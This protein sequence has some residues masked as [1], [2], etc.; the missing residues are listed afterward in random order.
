MNM[1]RIRRHWIWR[2]AISSAVLC[3]QS[4][5]PT[6]SI[7]QTVPP[8]DPAPNIATPADARQFGLESLRTAIANDGGVPLPPNL[9]DFIRDKQAALRLGKALFWDMQVGSDGVQAC[10][11]CHFE[12]GADDIPTYSVADLHARPAQAGRADGYVCLR[13]GCAEPVP[14]A[15]CGIVGHRLVDYLV[16]AAEAHKH[17]RL[18]RVIALHRLGQLRPVRQGDDVGCGKAAYLVGR[19]EGGLRLAEKHAGKHHEM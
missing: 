8:P 17:M 4:E 10:A 5:Y 2:I 16:P 13:E 11:S 9:G 12:G 15:K 14:H 18:H 7:A 3:I 1:I 6:R 19:P